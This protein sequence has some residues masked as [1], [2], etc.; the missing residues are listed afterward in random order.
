MLFMIEDW[1]DEARINFPRNSFGK[2]IAN[3]SIPPVPAF[4]V[5]DQVKT[6]IT[7]KRDK[8]AVPKLGTVM[9]VNLHYIVVNFGHY[10]ESYD[11]REL[12]PVD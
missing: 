7:N 6:I 11:P 12:V 8:K 3:P 1:L 9:I 4:Q 5:G 10:R 2:Q